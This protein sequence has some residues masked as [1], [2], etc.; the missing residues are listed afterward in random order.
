M[1]IRCVTAQNSFLIKI[2]KKNPSA[3]SPKGSLLYH[4]CAASISYAK[5]IYS[6]SSS[7]S[8]AGTPVKSGVRQEVL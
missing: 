8:V 1:E 2:R 6:S 3:S 5:R 7:G 4:A